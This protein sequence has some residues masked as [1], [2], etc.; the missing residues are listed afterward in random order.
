MNPV[1]ILEK[2]ISVRR[3][4]YYEYYSKPNIYDQQQFA[5]HG[6]AE[7]LLS[8]FERLAEA[9][10]DVQLRLERAI[11]CL[12]GWDTDGRMCHEGALYYVDP[13]L[14][15]KLDR[16][17][18]KNYPP[19]ATPPGMTPPELS[20]RAHSIAAY[21]YVK[22]Y[23][24]SLSELEMIACDAKCYPREDAQINAVDPLD[25]LLCAVGRANWLACMQFVTPAALMAGFA[26]KGLT[27]RLGVDIE[28]FKHYRPL[29]RALEQ[30]EQEL[31]EAECNKRRI[32]GFSTP[33]PTACAT[34][35]CPE[36]RSKLYKAAVSPCPGPCPFD[37]KPSYCSES[38]RNK[39]SKHRLFCSGREQTEL[40]L[41]IVAD[42][43]TRDRLVM[44]MEL[45]GPVEQLEK[46][47]C[48]EREVDSDPRDGVVLWVLDMP[49]LRDP[50]KIEVYAMKRYEP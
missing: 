7:A 49:S 25:N 24:A 1:D 21:A 26:F 15:P 27:E 50:T 45:R 40:P 11:R 17:A 4:C 9:G 34:S 12:S 32:T 37:M 30:R 3:S 20:L 28:G 42:Q 14:F 10:D 38:C 16:I 5:Q 22:K 2:Y 35:K 36:R 43:R 19:P 23:Y 18:D 8:Q 33:D 13:I 29:W 6:F 48:A 31:R 41:T 39:D 44:S 47:L 46:I